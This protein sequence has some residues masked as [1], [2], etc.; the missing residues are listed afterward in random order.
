LVEVRNLTAS[1]GRA[2][3][4]ERL[5]AGSDVLWP[6]GILGFHRIVAG[7]AYLGQIDGE[8]PTVWH[9]IIADNLFETMPE[10]C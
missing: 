1:H 9:R 6:I 2:L 8:P 10:G 4:S 3:E 7:D 5:I